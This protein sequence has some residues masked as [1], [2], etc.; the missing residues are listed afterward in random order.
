MS[1]TP[2][3]LR[4]SWRSTVLASLE[5]IGLAGAAFRVHEYVKALQLR[6]ASAHELRQIAQDG[7]PLPPAALMVLVG[8]AT[9]AEAFLAG[10]AAVADVLRTML[11]ADGKELAACANVLDFGCGCGRVMRHLRDVATHSR[12]HGTDYNGRLIRWC[13]RNL[14]FAT[15]A[16]NALE[17]P[18]AYRDATFDVVYAFSIFTHFPEGL[19]TRWIGEMA[20]VIAPGGHLFLTT[21]GAKFRHILTATEQAAFDRGEV[22]VRHSGMAGS[23]MCTAFHPAEYLRRFGTPWFVLAAHEP[24]RLGQDAVL[25][26]RTGEPL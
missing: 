6:R 2:P 3:T 20:R 4:R 24:E 10:G 11:R 18:L 26:R 9:T 21:H 13:R 14:P 17:P 12:L 1:L 23:N 15:F 16:K 5:R 8:G 19:Q 22:V 25:L 7:F